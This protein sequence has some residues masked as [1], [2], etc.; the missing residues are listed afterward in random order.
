[1]RKNE[2]KASRELENNR[3]GRVRTGTDS[4]AIGANDT[5]TE[6]AAG[7]LFFWAVI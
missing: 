2:G 4:T 1:M 7:V 3:E 5:R 6:V